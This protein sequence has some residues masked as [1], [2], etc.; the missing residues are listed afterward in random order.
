MEILSAFH[1]SDYRVLA[2]PLV[3][4]VS[5]RRGENVL[6]PYQIVSH[7][8]PS[9]LRQKYSALRCSGRENTARPARPIDGLEAFFAWHN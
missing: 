3:H 8:D 2:V 6:A 7:A 5:R 1:L 4:L 9:D